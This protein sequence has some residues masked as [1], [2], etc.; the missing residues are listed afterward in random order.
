LLF[1][2]LLLGFSRIYLAKHFLLDV[3]VGSVAGTFSGITA[4]YLCYYFK[5]SGYYFKKLF[6]QNTNIPSSSGRNIQPV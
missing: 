3:L 6:N 4:V 1:A 2:A 5:G